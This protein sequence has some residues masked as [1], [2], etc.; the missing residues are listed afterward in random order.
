MKQLLHA[1]FSFAAHRFN[2]M[3]NTDYIHNN[4]YN[5]SWPA[6]GTNAGEFKTGSPHS[7]AKGR[8]GY[9]VLKKFAAGFLCR[10]YINNKIKKQTKKS[11]GFET[12]TF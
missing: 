5:S 2:I 10:F 12:G 8:T 1:F 3:H 6:D 7:K 4:S 11:P 9:E